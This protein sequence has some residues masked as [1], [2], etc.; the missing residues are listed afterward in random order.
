M[1]RSMMHVVRRLL[2]G[3][4]VWQ[5]QIERELRRLNKLLAKRPASAQERQLIL[6]DLVHLAAQYAQSGRR[7]ITKR[8]YQLI[9][10]GHTDRWRAMTPQF[11][12]RY[13]A[14]A[15]FRRVEPQKAVAEGIEESQERV[16]LMETRQR[17]AAKIVPPL[18]FSSCRLSRKDLATLDTLVLGQG[19][20][21]ETLTR[22]R[23]SARTAPPPPRVADQ[24][25]LSAFDVGEERQ[26]EASLVGSVVRPQGGL[27]QNS[28]RLRDN[29]GH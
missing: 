29:R 10:K 23:T 28:S 9:M 4:S 27:R 7:T 5:V 13:E 20:R 16:S 1:V 2:S 21:G 3:P 24:Q 22:L 25:A 17:E 19:F 6:K 18:T 15:A 14:R 8:S 26:F 12:Q 11:R